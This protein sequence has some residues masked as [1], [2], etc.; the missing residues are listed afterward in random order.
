M[1]TRKS[2]RA[3]TLIELVVSTA[4]A[5]MILV[6]AYLCLGAG[7]AG[8]K[9]I[10]PRSEVIQSA[11][12]ALAIITSDLRAACAL[13][14]D[15]PFLGMQRT[16][17]GMQA[18]NIDFG[19][20]NYKPR[21]DREGDYCQVSYFMDKGSEPGQFSLWRRRNPTMAADPLSGGKRDE[22]AQ[23]LLGVSFQYYDGFDWYTTWG[24][25]KGEK[26]DKS[27]PKQSASLEDSNL[28]GMPEAVK[29]TLYFDSNPSHGTREMQVDSS[30]N[31]LAPMVFQTVVR[32]EL[33]S[34]YSDTGT[35]TGSG[36]GET[37]T[38]AGGS[39]PQGGGQ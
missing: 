11:R 30:T 21:R 22:I 20:H 13:S 24:E 1:R 16:L 17:S 18:D 31:R 9:S 7:V 38:Q 4:I 10:E 5:S 39:S 25:L 6:A 34:V 27:A 28:S 2:S 14:K 3:F 33:A 35:G 23:G 8:Q 32:L 12:V 36:T 15:T 29:V 19:T 37:G 26:P